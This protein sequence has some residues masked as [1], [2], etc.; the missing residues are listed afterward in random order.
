VQTNV[1]LNFMGQESLQSASISQTMRVA[2]LLDGL[3]LA[4]NQVRIDTP[5]GQ[6]KCLDEPL[7]RFPWLMISI[8]KGFVLTGDTQAVITAVFHPA[9]C[10]GDIKLLR[11]KTQPKAITL[12]EIPP[13]L[14]NFMTLGPIQFLGERDTP[15]CSTSQLYRL[16]QQVRPF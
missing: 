10:C 8:K 5:S 1:Y 15:S 14:Q 6:L 3:S 12:A 9:K 13:E 11:P 7:G 4:P 16:R 2:S